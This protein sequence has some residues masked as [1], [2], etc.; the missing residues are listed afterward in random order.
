MRPVFPERAGATTA[1]VVAPVLAAGVAAAGATLTATREVFSPAD[2]E[3]V[4]R[5]LPTW[6]RSR[7]ERRCSLTFFPLTK[8][9]TSPDMSRRT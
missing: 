3:K 2:S 7:S 5:S 4:N 1:R 8:V 6:I 9:P